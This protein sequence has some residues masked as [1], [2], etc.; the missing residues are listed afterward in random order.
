MSEYDKNLTAEAFRIPGD[1]NTECSILVA[2]DAYGMGI[3]NPDVRLVVQ[4]DFPISFDSMIQRMGRAGRKGGQATFV[5]F[6]PKWSRIK[7]P[8]EIEDRKAKTKDGTGTTGN[9]QLLDENRP[10]AKISQLNQVLNADEDLSDAESV[11]GSAAGSEADFDIDDV[12]EADLISGLLATEADETQLSKKKERKS[13]KSDAAKRANL[14]EEIFEYIHVARCRRLYALAWYDDMTY[15]HNNDDSGAIAT[16]AL[17]QL[18]CNGSSCQSQEPDFMKRDFFIDTS[19]PKYT[20]TDR[21]WIACRSSALKVWRKETSDRLWS[22]AGVTR[23]MS[24]TLLMP[25]AYLA[26]LAKLGGGL[27]NCAQLI[28]FLKPWYGVAKHADEILLCLQKNSPSTPDV[29]FDVSSKAKRKAT[30]KALRTS[31][32]LKYMDDPQVAEEARLTTLRDQWL[33]A[34]GKPTPGTKARMKKA[35]EAEKSRPRKRIKLVKKPKVR[36]ELWISEDLQLV[37]AEE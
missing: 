12:D 4:W 11:A 18:C 8:K 10:I 29:L 17:P 3:D 13:N 22:A 33:I 1:E 34:H 27:L 16:K 9:A 35:A 21:E 31:K 14:S 20:E 36:A 28:D 19:T 24:D 2:T 37:T 25:D 7:D 26:A 6:T 30:L 32:K 5:L 23:S 15:A